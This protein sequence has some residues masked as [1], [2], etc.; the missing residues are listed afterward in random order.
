MRLLLL[1]ILLNSWPG[2]ILAQKDSL[3]TYVRIISVSPKDSVLPVSESIKKQLTRLL[4]QEDFQ[5]KDLRLTLILKN[6]KEGLLTGRWLA[7]RQKKDILHVD[8]SAYSSTYIGETEK[9][10]DQLF[11][12]ASEGNM[13][14]LFDEADALFGKQAGSSE[15][16]N[17]NREKTTILLIKKIESYKGS[18]L[19]I[20][21]ADGCSVLPARLNFTRISG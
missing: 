10:L 13:I 20:C 5:K 6:Q 12:K 16:D 2:F 18:I 1:L 15:T 7:V 19:L 8:L 3:K 17:Q 21:K 11:Q 4:K 14:L 9:N